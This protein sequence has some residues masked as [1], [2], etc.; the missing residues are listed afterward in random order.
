MAFE[1]YTFR[2]VVQP[3]HLDVVGTD[4]GKASVET[5]TLPTKESRNH[6][7]RVTQPKRDRAA[8]MREYRKKPK[9]CPHC[10][11]EI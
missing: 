8:Y 3:T 11:K 10:G 7:K 5:V 2:P 1:N 4:K 9:K 6:D